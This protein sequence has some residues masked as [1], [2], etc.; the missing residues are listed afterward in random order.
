MN[1]V[2]VV[3]ISLF[4]I[5]LLF[6]SSRMAAFVYLCFYFVYINYVMPF[7]MDEQYE[8]IAYLFFIFT[9]SLDV[10][11]LFLLIEKYFAVACLSGLLVATN[12]LGWMLYENYYP[13]TIYGIIAKSIIFAQIILLFTRGLNG[14]F[15]SS[16]IY[17]TDIRGIKRANDSWLVRIADLDMQA[18]NSTMFKKPKC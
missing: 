15:A 8:N 4:V 3:I 5:L 13:P 6:R 14:L 9:A 16:G 2:N 12:I 10:V 1:T 7:A 17:W 18:A 11:I